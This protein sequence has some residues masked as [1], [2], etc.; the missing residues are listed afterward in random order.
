[1]LCEA[2]AVADVELTPEAVGEFFFANGYTAK[3]KYSNMTEI[4]EKAQ[5]IREER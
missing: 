4:L 3:R 2:A 5:T 1:M